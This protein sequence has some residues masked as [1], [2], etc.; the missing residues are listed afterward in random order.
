MVGWFWQLVERVV[1][2]RSNGEVPVIEALGYS[3]QNRFGVPGLVCRVG[4]VGSLKTVA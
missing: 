1:A 4:I 2:I 3:G